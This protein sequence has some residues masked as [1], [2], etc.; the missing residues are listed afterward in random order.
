MCIEKEPGPK[1]S[2]GRL[3]HMLSNRMKRESFAP[4]DDLGLTPM[5][6][7]VLHYILFCSHSRDV[8]QKDVERE[9]GIRRPTASGILQIIEKKGFITRE[10]EERDARLKRLVPTEKA[11]ELKPKILDHIRGMNEKLIA[12]ISED[13]L[14]ACIGVLEKMLVNLK[15]TDECRNDRKETE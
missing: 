7:Y 13:E 5:Q 4:F 2:P 3:I 6:K 8:Y 12:G 14:S 1:A 11:E 15:T 9:F 10:S